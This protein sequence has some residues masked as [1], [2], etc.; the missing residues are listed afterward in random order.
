MRVEQLGTPGERVFING[1][2]QPAREARIFTGP[3][4]SL[5]ELRKGQ[6]GQWSLL[7]NDLLVEDYCEGKRSSKDESLRE[8]R[9]KPDGS[10]MISTGFDAA[11]LRDL[12]VIRKF[13][14]AASGDTHELEVAHWDCIWQVVFDGKIVD[15]VVHRLKDNN[16]EASFK[17][18]VA[19]GKRLDA[20]LHMTW[21]S[22]KGIWR[23]TLVVNSV[24]IPHCWSKVQGDIDPPPPVLDV[25]PLASAGE[26]Q[27][28][29]PEPI[30]PRPTLQEEELESPPL[31]R[32]ALPQGV[33][34][35]ALS[36]AYQANVRSKTGKF[37]F[38]GEFRTVDEAHEC[39]LKAL[40]VHCPEK[41]VAPAVPT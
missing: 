19:G 7:V 20:G 23:Y 6:A 12:N 31:S 11:N 3:G 37:V 39:Y 21:L 36:G 25:A 38:L 13:R 33:S 32:E 40:P 35:D 18:E 30:G 27:G 16:G 17:L 28:D 41:L 14:F 22:V 5:L 2:Q 8:L 34:F 29:L 10:Y 26:A 24:E 4:N 9:G 1:E 15:R